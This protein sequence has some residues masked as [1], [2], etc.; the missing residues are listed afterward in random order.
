MAWTKRWRK[1]L[2]ALMRR[3]DVERELDEELA[4]HLE[5]ETEKN[6][7]AGMSPAEARRRAVLEFGGVEKHKEEVRDARWLGGFNGLSLDARLGARMLVKH[8]GLTLVGGLGMAVAIAI[9]AIFDA[10]MGA[11]NSPMPVEGGDRIVALEVWNAEINNQEGRF[12]YDFGR[13][14]E[15]VRTVESLG[16]FRT[17][18]RNLIV[19]GE[20]TEPMLVAEMSASGF[21]ILRVPPLL[22]RPLVEAD[23]AEGAAPVAVIGYET[24]RSRFGGDPRVVGREIR[25]GKAV[26]TVVGVMPRGFEFPL[27][28]HVWVPLRLS[29]GG[30]APRTGPAIEAFGRLAPGVSLEEAQ[31][32]VATVGKRIAA[33]SPETHRHM[34]PRVSVYGPHLMDDFQGW[35]IPMMRGVITLLLLVIAV[36]VSVLVFARTATRAGEITVRSALGASRRRIVTQFFAEG[37]VLSAVSAVVGLAIAVLVLRQLHAIMDRLLAPMGGLPFWLDFH[38]SARAVLFAVAMAALAAVIVGIVPALRATGTR[39]ESALRAIGGSTGMALGRTWSVLIV[40]Q[41][42]FTVAIIPA[43]VFY[44]VDFGRYGMV[45]PGL[46]A[47]EFLTASLV[48][49]REPRGQDVADPEAVRKAF[50]A[51]YAARVADLGRRLEA[52]PGV[53]GAATAMSL[54]GEEPTVRFEVEGVDAP[55]TGRGFPVNYNRV[56]T[57]YFGT[58]G[59]GAL[60]GRLFEAADMGPAATPVV[61]NR[62]F[63]RDVLGGREALG[64]RVRIAEGYRDGGVMQVP[65]GIEA[66]RWYE[67]VGIV[68]NLPERAMEPGEPLAQIYRPLDPGAAYPLSLVIHTR[69]AA[70]EFAPR[71]TELAIAVDPSLQG[72]D[73]QSLATVIRQFQGGM[74][75]GALGLGLLTGSVLLLSAAGIYA[76][77]SFTVT[78]RRREIG[79]RAALGAHPRRILAAIFSRA[80]RQLGIGAAIGLAL[81]IALNF[82]SQGETTGGQARIVLP[83]VAAIILVVGLLATWGPA[84]RG[85][86]IQ[87]ME[88]LKA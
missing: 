42:A 58:F 48:M 71:L 52:E 86:R 85:L 61:V 69:G 36:N 30:Y 79:L 65:D 43:T 39:L 50:E 27:N 13:W 55:E 8:P 37:L 56:D 49:D 22:G 28:Q 26:H 31:A 57:R 4:F 87:P 33:A 75:M 34:R 88:A 54:P 3:D 18:T 15:E 46:P 63:V 6:V 64:R 44:A 51:R 78:Q 60:S 25:L 59:L 24:W 20:S 35:E 77:M 70:T 62:A 7:R 83:A 80:A 12:L 40:A 66:G 74:R 5:M 10:S 29:P 1:R 16:A 41:V 53:I 38:L 73:V 45:D 14:R 72:R 11:A 81:A 2:R 84:R 76:L 9:A 17:I 47:G 32:E 23:E 67:I 68:G 21:G 82:A 19:D